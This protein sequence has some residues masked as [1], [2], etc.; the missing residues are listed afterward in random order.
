[1]SGRKRFRILVVD[2]S[3]DGAESLA[4]MLRLWGHETHTAHDGLEGVEAANWFNP[5]V[6]LLD[7]GMPKLN[8][9]EAARRIRAEPW[10]QKM[11]LVAVTG[12]GQDEDRQQ[13]SAAG[14]DGHMTKPVDPAA[15]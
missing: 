12:W 11:V 4:L 2:D 7:I 15:L 1:T 3:K 10:G 5:H 9:Y 13:A 8:G 14:F 6:V